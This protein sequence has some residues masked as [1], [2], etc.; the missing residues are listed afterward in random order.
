M[1]NIN[2]N[3]KKTETK[4]EYHTNCN[5]LI[6]IKRE[7]SLISNSQDNINNNKKTISLRHKKLNNSDILIQNLKKDK[8]EIKLKKKLKSELNAHKDKNKNNNQEHN[9]ELNYNINKNENNLEIESLGIKK[10]ISEQEYDYVKKINFE[11][12]I[13]FNINNNEKN[14]I[15]KFKNNAI[16][17]TKYNIFTF[18]PKGLL[19]QFYRFSNVYFLISTIIQSI[20]YLNPIKTISPI[21]SLIFALGVSMIREA[22]E[23]LKKYNYDKSNNEEEVLVYRNN[24]FVKSTSESLKYGEIILVYEN[25]NIPADIIVIDTGLDDGICYV[26]IS[27]LDGER[28]LKLKVANKYTQGFIS[29]D[30]KGNKNIEKFIQPENYFF[31]GTIEI[32]EPNPNL[33]YINGRFH[34]IFK[35]YDIVIDKKLNI[36]MNEFILKGSILKNTNWII[37][38]VV[39]TGMNNKIILNTK[40]S[41]LKVSKIE[42]KLNI[43]LKIMCFVLCILCLS[44]SLIH[45]YKY[46]KY[47]KY[48]DN[49]ILLNHSVNEESII[50]FFSY[51]TLLNTLIP[52]S[53]VVSKEIIKM[54]QGIF[55]R[56][57]ILLY[58]KWKHCFCSAKSVSIIEDLGNVNIIFSDKTGTLTKNKLQFKYCIIDNKCYEYTN[59][60]IKMQNQ[61]S[62]NNHQIIPMQDELRNSSNNIYNGLINV[63][64]NSN[65]NKYKNISI[66]YQKS[67]CEKTEN[68]NRL[69]IHYNN[70]DNPSFSKTI[71]ISKKSLN[72]LPYNYGSSINNSHTNIMSNNKNNYDVSISSNISNIKPGEKTKTNKNIITILDKKDEDNMIFEHE[73]IQIEDGYFSVVENNPFIKNI[74]NDITN[75]G[76][77]INYIHEFWLALALANECK[78]KYVKND[79]IKYMGASPDDLELVK[80]AMKQGYKLVENSINIKAIKIADRNNKFEILKVLGFSSERKRMSIIVR[81]ERNEIKLYI[82]GADCEINKRLSKL[83]LKNKN[84]D[85]ISR[86]LNEF[87]KKGYRTLMIAYKKITNEEYNT[88]INKLNEKNSNLDNNEKIIDILYDEIENNLTL[89][90]GTIVDDELQ[91]D[92]EETIKEIKIAGIKMW[93]LTGDK[94]DTAKKIGYRCKILSNEQKIFELK[95]INKDDIISIED[96]YIELKEFFRQFQEYTKDLVKKYNL[97]LNYFNNEKSNININISEIM[98][99]Q[100]KAPRSIFENN[101]NSNI[102][103]F[104]IFKYLEEKNIFEKFS[105]IIESPLLDIIFKDEKTTTLFLRIADYSDTVICCRITSSQKSLVIK[106]MKKYEKDAVTLA[107]GDGANDIP[108]IIEANVGIGIQREEGMTSSHA[109]DFVIGEFKLLKRLLFA[110]GRTN[111]YRNSNM[112]IYFFYKN[113]LLT[114]N[115]L[116]YAYQCLG[117]GQT[118]F[119]DWNISLY[120]LLFTSLPLCISALTDSDI[121]IND[122]KNV[123]NFLALLYK[124]NRDEYQIFTLKL[125]IWNLIKGMI[126]SFIIY[127]AGC[128]NEILSSGFNKSIWYMS[129]KKYICILIIVSMNLLINVYFISF[130]LLLAIGITTFLLFSIFLILNHYGFFLHFNSKATIADVLSSS[131]FYLTIIWVSLLNFILDYSTKVFKLYFRN[132]LSSKTILNKPIKYKI[133]YS[134]DNIKNYSKNPEKIMGESFYN[135]ENEKS[136]NYLIHTSPFNKPNLMQ[137]NKK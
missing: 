130:L 100:K 79:Q 97:N 102:I 24:E 101:I 44:I 105:I 12:M 56:W 27:S 50:I 91:D 63:K 13:K 51:F 15:Y 17:T 35:K 16:S 119:D 67:S 98:N 41:R 124:E 45:H 30:I 123:N 110:H 29:T 74:L 6:S 11:K 10:E 9:I 107:I 95:V 134:N 117:S 61:T 7:Y 38:I 46:K 64:R 109:S 72:V 129:L 42:K 59:G 40:M 36:S 83:S 106:K 125:L 118:I 104:E 90:G 85:I 18:I 76:N 62:I 112:I 54:M 4:N 82:K 58:S 103:N 26:E 96:H 19:C 2:G 48:Y 3:D 127:I 111:L 121:N 5:T 20:C 65:T 120:N 80:V 84:Y 81:D 68:N 73:I 131:Q 78:I 70:L 135:N 137:H 133:I 77:L 92:V 132:S 66:I 31:N 23:D 87:S 21:I 71:N 43:Y 126:I 53:L 22:N 28:A 25:H 94:L 69:N 115:Q 33:N 128:D 116:Y 88:W 99:N 37:G 136:R 39:Y 86:G 52:I 57:D 93:I 60:S 1:N 113:F 122:K 75:N 32:N 34:P 8:S 89:L 14:K 114:L 55:M 108:M 47:K 49:F